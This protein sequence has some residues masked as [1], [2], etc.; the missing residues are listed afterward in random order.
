MANDAQNTGVGVFLIPEASDPIVA[1]SSEQAH[2][3]TIW[4]GDMNDLDEDK[5]AAIRDEIAAYAATL[6]GPVVVPTLDQGVLG[7]DEAAV[8]FLEPTEALLAL[9]EG[10]LEASPTVS[11]VMNSVERYPQWTP[12][13][14]LGYPETPAAGEYDGDAVTFDRVGL[15]VGPDQEEFPMSGKKAD[16]ELA[17]ARARLAARNIID[18]GDLEA[19]GH[20]DDSYFTDAGAAVVTSEIVAAASKVTVKRGG[21]QFSTITPEDVVSESV[22]DEMPADELEDDEEEI[23]E[24][25]VHG[26][27]T[28][29]GRSTGDGRGFRE[30]ALQLG[31]MPQP[32]GYEYVSTHGGDTSHVAV[33]G[34]IDSYERKDIGNGE[35]ELRW[36]GVIM[37]GKPY[38]AQAIESIID[39]S[40]TGLSVIVDSVTVDMTEEREAFRQRF[41]AE[42]DADLAADVDPG[43]V[44]PRTDDEIEAMIDEFV[45]D[46]TQPVT[47]FSAARVR[48]FDMVPTGAFQEAYIK[49]G[50]EFD[51]ELTEEQ[52][53]AAAQALAD[54][55]CADEMSMEDLVDLSVGGKYVVE[56]SDGHSVSLF[57]PF[58]TQE[59]AQAWVGS[60]GEGEYQPMPVN[61]A[62]VAAGFRDI[63]A[64]ERK[65]LADS[66]DAMPD[67]SYPIA[68]VEDL[69]NAIQAIGRAKD[70]EAVKRHIEKR[71]R[72][73]GQE[74][75]I[76]EGWA[77]DAVVAAGFAPGTK[78]GPGWITHPVPTARIRRYWVRGKGAAKIRWGTP[79]DFN[80]CRAQLAKYVQN[81]E[82]LA[83][84]CANMHKEAIGVWP[85]QETGRHS[86]LAS[87]TPAPLVTMADDTYEHVV[88]PAELFAE[89]TEDHAFGLRVDR[90]TGRVWGYAADWSSCHI[91]ISGTCQRAP[92]SSTDYSFFRKGV[93]DT[94]AG[95]QRVGLITSGVGHADEYMGAAA[96]TAHYDQTDA[97]RAYINIGENSKGIWYSGVLAPGITE[98]QIA[99]MRAIGRVSGDWRNWSGRRGDL[100]M[101]GLVVVNTEGFQLAASGGI[102]TAAIG[103]G[104]LP[105]EPDVLAASAEIVE[106]DEEAMIDRVADRVIEKQERAALAAATDVARAALSARL[107]SNAR[108]KLAKITKE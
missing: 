23:T 86:I 22:D 47:W 77:A 65:K 81:P 104:A 34:R 17:A 72:E 45:G 101:V 98:A 82:W 53:V 21:L 50:H 56:F 99:E 5:I 78:D 106:F 93:V 59:E 36:R 26:V 73:L 60:M 92:H 15:W 84:L 105:A 29:E 100:E 68:N 58:D 10:M 33:V 46:G 3:T 43:E 14:T 54:C 103:L 69:R 67:G 62:L 76:P 27:A 30:N 107:L 88:Y 40:Y 52:L 64:E 9:R 96:A 102:Q 97:I 83:G 1:A 42:R 2:M 48:R 79:G 35:Y 44:R 28:V 66:G 7:D 32:L 55:G 39:G 71:A 80:R 24:I 11:A 63:S 57:G 8:Q 18:T 51:D 108:A 90:E 25:P 19:L 41:I 16:Q 95:E 75:M 31:A 87:A 85:G 37:P 4:L 61:Q 38:G 94:T 91:G 6:D 13:V 49:L 12:H 74:G 70:P 89:P 20:A